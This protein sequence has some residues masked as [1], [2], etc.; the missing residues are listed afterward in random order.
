MDRLM[1][2]AHVTESPTF[3]VVSRDTLFDGLFLPGVAMAGYDVMR[4]GSKFLMV[5]GNEDNM[6]VVVVTNWLAELK[7][8][9]GRK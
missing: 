1:M 5:K 2:A 7:A 4:D 3:A 9:T 8:R 6:Q